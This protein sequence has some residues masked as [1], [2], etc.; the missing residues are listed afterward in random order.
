MG[1]T[2]VDDEGTTGLRLICYNSCYI[3]VDPEDIDYT[4]PEIPEGDPTDADPAEIDEDTPAE[5]YNTGYYT[6]VEVYEGDVGDW[7]EASVA[8]AGDFV[9]GI[10][11]KQHNYVG[12]YY[13]DF[14]TTGI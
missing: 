2:Y 8:A 10:G 11:V 3:E 1:G 13:D 12:N 14:G 5:Q 9:A 4:D 6:T 7:L